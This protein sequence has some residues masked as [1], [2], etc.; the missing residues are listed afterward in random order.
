M[1]RARALIALLLTVCWCAASCHAGLEAVGLMLEHKHWHEHAT[2]DHAL[3]ELGGDGHEEVVARS[4]AKDPIRFAVLGVETIFLLAFA[5]WVA[6]VWRGVV[7][8][9]TAMRQRCH[10]DPPTARIWQFVQRCAPAALAPPTL[11]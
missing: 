10:A 6:G 4:V 3:P 8:A 9:R 2:E 7:W 1:L 5:G 11:G